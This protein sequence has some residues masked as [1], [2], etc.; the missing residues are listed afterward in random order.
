M[1]RRRYKRSL[2]QDFYLLLRLG[3]GAIGAFMGGELRLL[4]K[5]LRLKR[6]VGRAVLIAA[7]LCPTVP[8]LAQL[9]SWTDENGVIHYGNDPRPESSPAPATARPGQALRA[10]DKS[11]GGLTL[12]DEVSAFRAAK[13][14]G[15]LGFQSDGSELFFIAPRFLPQ[16]ATKMTATFVDGRLSLIEVTYPEQT[17]GGWEKAL[18]D[19]T[20]KYGEP[21]KSTVPAKVSWLDGR[22]ILLFKKDLGNII[23]ILADIE[24]TKRFINRTDRGPL[25]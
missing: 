8:A 1:R 15:S 23:A 12:G 25:F 21:Q 6:A 4:R 10:I 11:H 3:N 19:Q 18:N 17:L 14:G 5:Y 9:K 2:R 20:T 13:K 7:I 22:T 24:A 16:G